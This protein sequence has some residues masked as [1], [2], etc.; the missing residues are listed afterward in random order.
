[1]SHLPSGSPHFKG[2]Y[3]QNCQSD[4][5]FKKALFEFIETMFSNESKDERL[6]IFKKR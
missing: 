4:Y 1:M 5:N 3:N 6:Y 2:I